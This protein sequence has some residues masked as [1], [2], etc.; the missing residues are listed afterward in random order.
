MTCN[1]D[2]NL[3]KWL[4]TRGYIHFDHKRSLNF[5]KKYVQ[6]LQNIEKHSFLPFL[7][8]IKKKDSYCAK[9][10]KTNSKPRPIMYASHLDS[11]IYSWYSHQLSQHY[12]KFIQNNGIAECVL[13][14]RSLG[15]CNIN[16][17]KEVFD[18]IVRKAPCT[19][20]TFDI[21]KF[22]DNIDHKILKQAWCNILG[23]TELPLDHYKVYKSI[24]KY[25]YVNLDAVFKELQIDR[26]QLKEKKRIC[27]SQEFRERVRGKGLVQ[28]NKLNYGIPQGSPISAVFSNIFLIH[29]DELMQKHANQINGV[30][31][32]Y[33][34]DILWICPNDDVE[35]IKSLVIKEIYTMGGQLTINDK[36]TEISVFK[37]DN[38]KL[39]GTPALQYL[40][41][42]F[43]GQRRLIRSQTVG[44]YCRRMKT[45]VRFA[46]V[47]ALN[48]GYSQLYRK[49]IYR[50]Y[51]HLG[52][53]NFIRYANRS[54]EIMASKEIRRQIRRHWKN[55]HKEIGRINLK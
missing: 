52:N 6:N 40:G 38:D 1:S 15:K 53:N 51:S 7:K 13:A 12:E 10:N 41:F 48:A 19:V 34:D 55:L 21:S 9:E 30:Y 18:E 29:F 31:R 11:H 50:K 2:N 22:F 37:I 26:E 44:R 5:A 43:D 45:A 17:S 3:E 32:R 25:S 33:C 23:V 42:T 27:S 14:Y 49:S 36:K 54:A 39:I 20:L 8:Y 16:F 35:I 24:T 47:A 28:T 4:R 46:G